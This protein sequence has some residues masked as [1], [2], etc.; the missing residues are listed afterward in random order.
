[1]KS[2]TNYSILLGLKKVC[3]VFS[4]AKFVYQA[5]KM[6]VGGFQTLVFDQRMTRLSVRQTM[7]TTLTTRFVFLLLTTITIIIF[8]FTTDEIIDL[9]T[10]AS[11]QLYLYMGFIDFMPIYPP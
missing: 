10:L 8:K 5:V 1:M 9:C 11:K 3:R 4:V 7:F 2:T 6:L